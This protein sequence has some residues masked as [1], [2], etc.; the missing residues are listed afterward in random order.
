M[1][2]SSHFQLAVEQLGNNDL[3]RADR[4]GVAERT[5]RNWRAAMPRILRIIAKNPDLVRALVRDAE[6][7]T[8]PPITEL[9][10]SHTAS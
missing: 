5:A 10:R 1:N 6:D 4:L 7:Q 2:N 9:S 3:E 8:S